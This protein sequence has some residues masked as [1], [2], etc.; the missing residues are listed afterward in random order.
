[1]RDI[2]NNIQRMVAAFLLSAMVLATFVSCN[3]GGSM[4][5]QV[6]SAS[7]ASASSSV[8]SSSSAVQSNSDVEENE[9]NALTKN[10]FSRTDVFEPQMFVLDEIAT[11]GVAEN[12]FYSGKKTDGKNFLLLDNGYGV[13][14]HGLEIG[15]VQISS[16][17]NAV[18]F[19]AKAPGEKNESLYKIETRQGTLKLVEKACTHIFYS[20]YADAVAVATNGQLRYYPPN[21][22]QAVVVAGY[23]PDPTELV[24]TDREIV[25]FSPDG[26]WM[27]YVHNG[28]LYSVTAGGKPRYHANIEEEY[29]LCGISNDGNVIFY[30]LRIPDPPDSTG[31]FESNVHY[32]NLTYPEY[33]GS[34]YAGVMCD[35]LFNHDGSQIL[36]MS[37]LPRLYTTS[38]GFSDTL[39][40]PAGVGVM[41]DFEVNGIDLINH[42]G[43]WPPPGPR[44]IYTSV[45]EFDHYNFWV[46]QNDGATESYKSYFYQN[47][48]PY[49]QIQLVASNV[50]HS[51]WR[52]LDGQ[53]IIGVDG[54]ARNI[55]KWY[56]DEDGF[57]KKEI[58]AETFI[59]LSYIS[60]PGRVD[61]LIEN[62]AVFF[63]T[64]SDS[65]LL[66]N[67][68]L[69]S[70]EIES[71]PVGHAKGEQ[72]GINLMYFAGENNGILFST[73]NICY[74]YQPGYSPVEIVSGKKLVSFSSWP[75]KDELQSGG[76]GG[77]S[78]F[79]GVYDNLENE[80]QYYLFQD[81]EAKQ[82]F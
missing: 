54:P 81:G 40:K 37:S 2:V 10:I 56:I 55:C 23:T 39:N 35:I 7:S 79:F 29:K 33:S 26:S 75:K 21:N 53:Q 71:Y 25:L 30:S 70:G 14:L 22:Q 66:L 69:E 17:G 27:L 31:L 72:E 18:Y 51:L 82:I 49:Y 11:G 16:Q 65:A 43:G 67:V 41:G 60:G 64:N 42:T 76:I 12:W 57:A 28:K 61:E 78:I 20:K 73:E 34:F 5:P 36:T 38:E 8:S 50:D 32:I 47:I 3:A 6:S 46:T 13:N 44:G 68:V 24:W 77:K 62:N 19:S 59:P 15:A 45:K 52:S 9:G 63:T 74:Y 58:L 4:Q 80:Q 1:M 48:L